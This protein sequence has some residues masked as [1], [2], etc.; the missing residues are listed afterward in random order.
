[1]NDKSYIELLDQAKSGDLRAWTV[2]QNRFSGFANKFAS[3]ILKDEDL[4]QD[5]VQES[6]W[7]L[8]QNLEKIT[9]PAAFPTLLKRALIKH[10]DRILRK[11]ENQNLVFVDPN[12]MDQNS[13][14]LHSSY[15]EKE[16]Y[17]TIFKNV[18]KLDLADQRL[19]ELYYYKNYSLVEISK[20]EGKTLS[21]IKKRHIH[22]KKILRHG[23][24]E[25]FRPEASSN[26][27][28]AA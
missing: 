26:F 9:I 1:M 21:F 22:V 20:S 11:K 16:C 13:E 17:E 3:K 14:E 15:L 4:S 27:M 10:G 6:F 25:T 2:L 23:I 12:Q 18:K 28:M 19:I 7:D 5:I 24:G 8:Y